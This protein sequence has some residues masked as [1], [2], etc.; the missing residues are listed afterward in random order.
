[1]LE[2]KLKANSDATHLELYSCSKFV[3]LLGAHWWRR[4]LAGQCV[5]VAV[6]PGLVP[7]TG[8]T[9]SVPGFMNANSPDAR[10]VPDGARSII[11]AFT[12]SDF[13]DDPDQIFLTSWGEWW[14]KNVYKESLDRAL[15]DKW[16]PSQE[17]IE[18]EEGIAA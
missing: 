3:Q 4:E 17:Q 7:G 12:R 6:S 14:D 13:P 1:V 9:R 16:S 10:S 15:Q 8:L 5:V 11:A 18:R 2:E